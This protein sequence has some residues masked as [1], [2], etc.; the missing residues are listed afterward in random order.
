MRFIVE[1]I[2]LVPILLPKYELMAKVHFQTEVQKIYRDAANVILSV[3]KQPSSFG[4]GE[5]AISRQEAFLLNVRSN[6]SLFCSTLKIH[7][8]IYYIS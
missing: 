4:N 2:F 6:M 3:V 7:N 8:K 1:M 5:D